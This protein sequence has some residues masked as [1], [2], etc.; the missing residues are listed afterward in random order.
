MFILK[1]ETDN[2]AF[3]DPRELPLILREVAKKIEL[4]LT[5]EG[6]HLNIHDTNGNTV[7]TYVWQKR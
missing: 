3:D 2:S 1:V 7:G 5:G 6:K 4:G